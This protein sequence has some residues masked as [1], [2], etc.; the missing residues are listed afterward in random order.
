MP[1]HEFVCRDCEAQFEKLVRTHTVLECPECHGHD[2]EKKLSAFAVSANS[3]GPSPSA[4]TM[5][6][7][8]SPCGSCGHP[9]GP[10]SC[11]WDN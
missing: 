11:Q 9:G 6:A 10:G 8:P 2:L 5:D 1:L 7:A 3:F 4:R